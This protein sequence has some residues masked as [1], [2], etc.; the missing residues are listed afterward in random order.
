MI[1]VMMVDLSLFM[2]TSDGNKSWLT[3]M[4]PS[5]TIINHTINHAINI[6]FSNPTVGPWPIPP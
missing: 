2:A 3:M 4:E 5:L 6:N 1:D